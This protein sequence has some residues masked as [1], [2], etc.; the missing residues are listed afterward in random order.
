MRIRWLPINETLVRTAGELRGLAML[1][2]LLVAAIIVFQSAAVSR[3]YTFVY[4]TPLWIVPALAP[5]A[6]FALLGF[7]LAQS[8]TGDEPRRDWLKRRL[9]RAWPPLIAA[10]LLAVLAIG[11]VATSRGVDDYFTDPGTALYLLNVIGIPEFRLPGVFEFN[12]LSDMVNPILWAASVFGAL[13]LIV[14]FTPP[15]ARRLGWTALAVLICAAAG[16]ATLARIEPPG[17]TSS[18]AYAGPMTGALLSGLLG[19]LMFALREHVPYD[20]RLAATAGLVVAGAAMG[21][22]RFAASGLILNA[23]L[24]L[25]VAYLTLYLALRR[26]RGA[27]GWAKVQ[28]YLP[29]LLLAAFPFQQAA[30]DFGPR[31]QNMFVNL[32]LSLPALLIFALAATYVARLSRIAGPPR[33]H[34]WD[35]MTTP[36]SP[37]RRRTRREPLAERLRRMLFVLLVG[38]ILLALALG[39][40]A[41]TFFALQR[42]GGGL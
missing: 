6:L 36:T 18:L 29:A 41:L 19:A 4:S 3:S 2:A 42:D 12:D 30:A 26:G 35:A 11:P 17:G 14:A 7:T 13:A 16:V 5:A 32:A 38:F 1:R 39:V 22:N 28:P 34:P 15:R 31:N 40:M 27:T 9:R 23:G 37:V 21:S 20:W 33:G 8:S 25:P 24:A 10:V